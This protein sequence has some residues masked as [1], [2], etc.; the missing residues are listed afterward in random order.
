M[1]TGTL[2]DFE[3]KS[4]KNFFFYSNH[5]MWVTD[6]AFQSILE[7]NDTAV[8]TVGYE[9]E[10][11]ILQSVEN[12]VLGHGHQ[13]LISMLAKTESA[14]VKKDISLSSKSG[15]IIHAESTVSKILFDNKEA[16]LI[17]LTD[18]TEKKLYRTMLEDAVEEEIGLKTKNQQLKN[19]AYINFHSA[20][21]PLANILGLVNVLNQSAITDQTLSKAIEFLRASSNELDELIKKLDPQ[22]Y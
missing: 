5:S 6:T 12:I 7:V 20:R 22:L 10:E 1:K 4:L 16:V 13:K 11:F 21:K 14:L 2:L 3:D 17:T 19:L 8:K 18:I 9:R 15:K